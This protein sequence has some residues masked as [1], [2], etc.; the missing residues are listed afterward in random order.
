MML[1]GTEETKSSQCLNI[2]RVY[3]ACSWYCTSPSRDTSI[4]AL[5]LRIRKK[6]RHREDNENAHLLKKASGPGA[7]SI[8][9]I[10][11]MQ[12]MCSSTRMKLQ[13]SRLLRRDKS[14]RGN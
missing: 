1:E 8:F 3:E 13:I 5:W 10:V 6:F 7:R 12:S 11:N 9:E 14:I 2:T 4:D